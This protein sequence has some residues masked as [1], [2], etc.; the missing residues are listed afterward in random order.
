[1]KIAIAS[2]GNTLNHNIDLQFG[3]CAFFVIYDKDSGGMEISPN[4]FRD[5]PKQA[6]LQAV[7]WLAS[8]N[9]KTLIAGDFGP[10][11]QPLLDQLSMQL[12]VL[13]KP[14]TRIQDIINLLNQ[15]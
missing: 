13:K 11:V 4:P 8:Q 6:G 9:I 7:K 14:D 3:H 1:M 10:K 5:A 15:Q 12:I 2:Q